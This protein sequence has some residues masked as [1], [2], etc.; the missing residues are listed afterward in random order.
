M[1]AVPDQVCK[2]LSK[3]EINQYEAKMK[4]IFTVLLS[5]SSL[6]QHFACVTRRLP[7]GVSGV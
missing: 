3:I 7:V 2:I 4:N 1:L 5:P 6:S